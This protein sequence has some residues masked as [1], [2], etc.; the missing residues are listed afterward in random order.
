MMIFGG[1]CCRGNAAGGVSFA[2]LCCGRNAA[3]GSVL[4]FVCERC[5]F[6]PLSP[7][8]SLRCV[9]A[10]LKYLDEPVSPLCR[11]FYGF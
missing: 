6:L 10:V 8:L 3:G 5:S 1:L 2:R 9:F 7:S 11:I 4:C